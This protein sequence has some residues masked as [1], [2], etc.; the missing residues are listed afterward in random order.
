MGEMAKS[1]FVGF[2][3]MGRLRRECLITEKIDGTNAQI[4][5]TEDNQFLI[6][7]KSQWITPDQDNHGFAQW[8][9]AH[10]EELLGLG[11]GRHFGEWWGNGIQ[12]GYGLPNGE[13]RWSLFNVSRWCLASDTPQRIPTADP[14]IEKY[15]ERLPACCG[16]VP[17][18][19]RGLFS[20]DACEAAIA[21]LRA[22]GSKAS[23]GYKLPEGIVVFHLAAN[24]GFKQT[25]IKD[26][27]PKFNYETRPI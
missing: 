10:R 24:I 14:R 15:Q 23:P 18:L 12:R 26:E 21:D 6:G 20:T 17:V 19:W 9:T 2:P 27:Q 22:N 25:L 5:I 1:E 16:L 8:A 7:T 13:K 4:C 3:K 11:I